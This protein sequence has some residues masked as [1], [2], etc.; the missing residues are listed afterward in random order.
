VD[1][2]ETRRDRWYQLVD[3]DVLDLLRDG[4]PAAARTRIEAIVG[5]AV[6]AALDETAGPAALTPAD[7]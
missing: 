2:F 3:S 1:D 4:R 5:P 7:G 6:A